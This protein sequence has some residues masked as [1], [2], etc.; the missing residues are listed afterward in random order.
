MK[1]TPDDNKRPALIRAAIDEMN[2]LAEDKKRLRNRLRSLTQRVKKELDIDT[3]DFV[4][5]YR[6]QTLAIKKKERTLNAVREVMY[7][8]GQAIPAISQTLTPKLSAVEEGPSGPVSKKN[9]II[10]V[11]TT[12]GPM[13]AHD[14][15][16]ILPDLG[17]ATSAH[18]S[19]LKQAGRVTH[20]GTEWSVPN[21]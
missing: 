15:K 17:Q 16:V 11:L 3:P 8:L 4:M 12:H 14:L 6:L 20:S 2:E 10:Q 9:L 7:A 19:Q 5:A 18:L 21:R 13:T 1:H